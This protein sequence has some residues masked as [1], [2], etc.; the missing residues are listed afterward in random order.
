MP[1]II[2]PYSLD[3]QKRISEHT[4]RL[5]NLSRFLREPRQELTLSQG[6]RRADEDQ[7][8]IFPLLSL[9]YLSDDAVLEC[10]AV[11]VCVCDLLTDY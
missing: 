9:T 8:K 7:T 11:C 1:H 6:T 10:S 5:E 3:Q 4:T 2:T